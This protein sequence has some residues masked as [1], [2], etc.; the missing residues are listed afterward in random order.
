M[1]RTLLVQI[2]KQDLVY[3]ASSQITFLDLSIFLKR[4]QR[5]SIVKMIV[6][7]VC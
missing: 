5:A 2:N 3:F 7:I 1:K 4:V 6:V